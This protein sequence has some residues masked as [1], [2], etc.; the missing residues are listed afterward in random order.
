MGSAGILQFTNMVFFISDLFERLF[1]TFS[2]LFQDLVTNK[3]SSEASLKSQVK[4]SCW[5][6]KNYGFRLLLTGTCSVHMNQNV[7]YARTLLLYYFS[8]EINGEFKMCQTV[9]HKRKPETT[10]IIILLLCANLR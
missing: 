2:F 10:T 3:S 8:L 1:V 4:T 5:N 7:L 6:F 9:Q